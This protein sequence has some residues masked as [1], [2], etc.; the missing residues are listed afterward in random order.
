MVSKHIK[1]RSTPFAIR[2][3]QIKSTMRYH[4]TTT[5]MAK[6]K[7]CSEC[8]EVVGQLELTTQFRWKAIQQSANAVNVCLHCDPITPLLGI[9]PKE[10][11]TYVCRETGTRMFIVVIFIKIKNQKQPKCPSAEQKHTTWCIHLWNIT[12]Q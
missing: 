12:Q 1:R 3:T 10:M 6:L 4:F 5:R 11:N 7:Y 8:W 9:N 2:E